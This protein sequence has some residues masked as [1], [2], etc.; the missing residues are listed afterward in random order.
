MLVLDEVDRLLEL[1]FQDELEE[2]LRYCP[3]GRQTMLFSATMTAKVE[4]LAKLSLRR[5]VR[6]KTGGGPTSVAP[7]LVQEFVKVRRED[8]RE[9]LVLALVC[10]SF[11]ERT[12]VFCETKSE[13]HRLTA[14]L[15]LMGVEAAELHGDVAQT[16]RYLAL[17]RFRDGLAAVLVATDVAARGLDIPLVRTVVNAEMPRSASTYIHRVGRTARAGCAGRSITLVSD[18]RRGVM[19]RVLK[20]DGAVLSESGQVL[21]RTVHGSVLEEFTNKVSSLE[22]KLRQS[23]REERRDKE[24]DAA[25]RE[26]ERAENLLR[27]EEEISARPARTWHQSEGQKRAVKAATKEAALAETGVEKEVARVSVEE[28]GRRMAL[29]DDYGEREERASHPVSR[30]KRRRQEALAASV[31]GDAGDKEMAE[32]KRA[33]VYSRDVFNRQTP[34]LTD[35]LRKL[36]KKVTRR[37]AKRN[38]TERSVSL[39]RKD[40]ARCVVLESRLEAS[41]LRCMVALTSSK[42]VR[43]ADRRRHSRISKSLT[44]SRDCGKAASQVKARSRARASSSDGRFARSLVCRFLL[45]VVIFPFFLFDRIL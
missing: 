29:S 37:S 28:R 20:G 12:I 24:M 21:S 3:A 45:R 44:L 10:R 18:G 2:L 39:K 22:E 19:K 36:F 27:F 33:K 25:E 14:L 9:A 4:D 5:P 41:M 35:A 43:A 6:V 42:A 30:L 13:A 23:L 31:E 32:A 34:S 7:R 17:Q 15:R 8:E 38:R 40:R 1:G 11:A 16:E 26:A